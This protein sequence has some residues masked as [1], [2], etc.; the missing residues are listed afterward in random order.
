MKILPFIL[1]FF[2]NISVAQTLDINTKKGYAANGY[3]VVSYFSNEAVEGSKKHSSSFKGVQYKFISEENLK[4]FNKNPEK[5]IP[6]YGG[7]C[8]Y[9]VALKSDKVSINP[10]SFLVKDGKLYLFYNAWGTNTLNLWLE[11]NPDKLT[12]EANVNW[13]RIKFK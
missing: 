4:V 3:D 13:E 8:A 6:Q 9:A 1:V 11:N 2:C 10:K 7:Y 5:Y 12:K